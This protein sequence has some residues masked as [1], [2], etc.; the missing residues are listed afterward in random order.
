M[1]FAF[2]D[3]VHVD[4]WIGDDDRSRMASNHRST[5]NKICA[6]D[7]PHR[8]QHRICMHGDHTHITLE[9]PVESPIEKIKKG[10]Y[11]KNTT[12]DFHKPLDRLAPRIIGHGDLRQHAR[13]SGL[14]CQENNEHIDY[15][16]YL[17]YEIPNNIDINMLTI[18]NITIIF[19][20]NVFGEISPNPTDV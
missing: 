19:A 20:M 16:N 4:Q 7:T 5:H 12:D 9:S 1:L 3:L 2:S 14:Y 8:I 13:P 15:S 18:C 6:Q 10:T 17:L 11:E